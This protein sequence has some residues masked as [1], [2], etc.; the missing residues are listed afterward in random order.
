MRKFR[1]GLGPNKSFLLRQNTEDALMFVILCKITYPLLYGFFFYGSPA[2]QFRK[3]SHP[4]WNLNIILVA[5]PP[6]WP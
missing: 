1:L 6:T 3:S 2:Q 4:L 5:L